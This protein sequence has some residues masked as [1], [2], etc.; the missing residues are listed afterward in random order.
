[1]NNFFVLF[2]YIIFKY[3]FV[4]NLMFNQ[5][6]LFPKILFVLGYYLYLDS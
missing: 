4:F 2:N 3:C 1:M 6:K 5:T